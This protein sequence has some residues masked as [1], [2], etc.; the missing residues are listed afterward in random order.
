MQGGRV[1]YYAV[2]VEKNGGKW[3]VGED[4]RENSDCRK[5]CNTMPRENMHR[6]AIRFLVIRL[7]R[8]AAKGTILFSRY[9]FPHLG[10][11]GAMKCV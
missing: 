4:Q 7:L 10:Q 9:G 3:M 11:P 8:K 5:S 2:Q 1:D 6:E